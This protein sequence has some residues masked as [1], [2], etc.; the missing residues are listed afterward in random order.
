MVPAAVPPMI[1]A[2]IGPPR[3]LL[4][5][6]LWDRLDEQQQ[7]A[8]L[9]HE[10]ATS[11]PGHWVR[12]LEAVVLGLYWWNPIA[13]WARGHIEQAEEQCC[14]SWVLWTLPG[15]AEAYAEALVETASFCQA[16]AC[17]GQ[18]GPP[19]WAVSPRYGG[20]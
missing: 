16:R 12:R 5:E 19:A 20:G 10:M 4:P 6:P 15:A 8:V 17:P 7:D 13:W 3:L 1:W 18:S 11:A 2:P 9:I 14:D